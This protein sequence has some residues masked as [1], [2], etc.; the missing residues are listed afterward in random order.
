M[1][2]T[3]LLLEKYV[4]SISLF[5]YENIIRY[6]RAYYSNNPEVMME[7]NDIDIMFSDVEVRLMPVTKK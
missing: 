4:Y 7:L 2:N 6:E 1:N 5:D 3:L